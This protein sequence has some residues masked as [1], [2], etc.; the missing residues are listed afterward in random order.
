M[1][2]HALF[3]ALLAACAEPPV[4]VA[5]SGSSGEA[6]EHGPVTCEQWRSAGL[7]LRDEIEAECFHDLGETCMCR[8]V[9][10][11]CRGDMAD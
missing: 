5:C 6:W 9:D 3:V 10:P 1:R 4:E 7:N 2:A 8:F 11:Q